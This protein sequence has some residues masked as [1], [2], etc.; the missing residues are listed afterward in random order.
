MHVL[1]LHCEV[2]YFASTHNPV[3]LYLHCR[4]GARLAKIDNRTLL[5]LCL[6]LALVGSVLMGDWQSIGHDPCFS[7]YR[8]SSS[9]TSQASSITSNISLENIPCSSTSFN[10][11]T[12]DPPQIENASISHLEASGATKDYVWPE[13]SATNA[14]LPQQLVK[15]CEALSN[16][17]HTC[18][19][20]RQSDITRRYCYTC[21]ATC[22]SRQKSQNIY[23]FSI[24]AL[25]L[26]ISAPVGF[27]L[28]SAI[29]SEIT[30]VKSQVCAFSFQD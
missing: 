30:S 28:I 17:K 12:S 27:V 13:D 5:G 16:S 11:T 8:N 1:I 9:D 2:F 15:N 25:F 6:L 4:L 18:Y 23:Q 7:S 22:L 29:A 26:C 24:G 20:N 10:T 3:A 19:W 14:G 21:L